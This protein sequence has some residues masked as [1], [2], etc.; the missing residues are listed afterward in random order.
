MNP[1]EIFRKIS[2][3]KQRSARVSVD[4]LKA[5]AR[6]IESLAA[7][8]GAGFMTQMTIARLNDAIKRSGAQEG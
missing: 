4:L 5:A 7:V 3:E 1:M 6:E 2:L 8:N